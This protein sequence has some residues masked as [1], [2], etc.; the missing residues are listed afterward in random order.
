MK[1]KNEVNFVSIAAK[2][3]INEKTMENGV[4]LLLFYSRFYTEYFC[5]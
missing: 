3:I 4:N 2:I 5:L 1:L